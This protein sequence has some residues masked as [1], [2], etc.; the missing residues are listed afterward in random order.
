MTRYD[1][2]LDPAFPTA[3]TLTAEQ[4][5]AAVT[6]LT[7]QH[8]EDGDADLAF[9]V[10]PGTDAGTWS[11]WLSDDA[12]EHVRAHCGLA[13]PDN[14][15]TG[16]AHQARAAE[17]AVN[18]G[19]AAGQNAAWRSRFLRITLQFAAAMSAAGIDVSA[20]LSAL[21]S[22]D[23][24][25]A[26]LSPAA[27][28]DIVTAARQRDGLP[29][30]PDLA[31][32]WSTPSIEQQLLADAATGHAARDWRNPDLGARQAHAAAVVEQVW[33]DQL[34]QARYGTLIP[35]LLTGVL[36][37]VEFSEEDWVELLCAF[38]ADEPYRTQADFLASVTSADLADA[39]ITPG[40]DGRTF[41]GLPMTGA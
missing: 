29:A 31:G 14:S 25:H 30:L 7:S 22:D 33:H 2:M 17:D 24:E 21:D 38:D 28:E 6:A 20:M 9:A 19:T 15:P 5:A 1:R 10:T 12:A 37:P 13:V 40:P 32:F 27:V 35:V 4:L 11:L 16:R 23:P 41:I 3:V 34:W 18:D 26:P 36:R 39:G 8:P